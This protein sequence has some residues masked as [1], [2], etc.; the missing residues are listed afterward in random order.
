MIKFIGDGG[1]AKVLKDV[2][3][4]MR[5]KPEGTIIAVGNNRDRRNEANAHGSD[6]FPRLIHHSA[7]VPLDTPI[8]EGTVIMAG[9][10]V[11]PGCRIGK[12]VI[13]NTGCTGDHD[14]TIEDFVHIAPGVHLCGGVHVGEGALMGVGSCAVPGAKIEPWSLVKAGTVA[15]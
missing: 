3:R 5:W 13:L 10:I 8:G 14:C 7:I 4:T 9:A 6:Q 2:A 15:K 1:H 12:H 11:Q